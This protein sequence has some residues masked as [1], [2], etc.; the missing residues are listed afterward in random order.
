MG[1]HPANAPFLLPWF[2]ITPSLSWSFTSTEPFSLTTL[3]QTTAPIFTP[4]P[5]ISL[6]TIS[7]FSC[8]MFLPLKC[9]VHSSRASVSSMCTSHILNSAGAQ[10]TLYC[11]PLSITMIGFQHGSRFRVSAFAH[12][13][14]KSEMPFWCNPATTRQTSKIPLHS[15]Q[16]YCHLQWEVADHHF[17]LLCYQSN[18][19]IIWLG[20]RI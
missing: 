14:S 1:L 10:K 13:V 9:K 7:L 15:P 5:Y 2:R 4:L 18:G 12:K 19:K 8:L 11:L 3:F 6:P 16:P 17:F 20:N